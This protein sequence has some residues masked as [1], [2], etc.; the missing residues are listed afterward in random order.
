MARVFALSPRSLVAVGCWAVTAGLAAA[1]LIL[2][3]LQPDWEIL[4]LGLAAPVLGVA[5][6]LIFATVGAVIASRQPWNLVGWIFC[7]GALLIGFGMFAAP[8][9]AYAL[10]VRPGSL[11]AGELVAWVWKWSYVPTFG[12]IGILLPLLFPNGRLA[13]AR[14]RPVLWL[15]VPVL[16]IMTAGSAFG[17]EPIYLNWKLHYVLPNAFALGAP[18]ALVGSG[19]LWH[20]LERV[21]PVSV[22]PL[23]IVAAISLVARAS[24]ADAVERQQIKW[25]AF[26]A[27]LPGTGF[28]ISLVLGFWD[29]GSLLLLVG[30]FGL[31]IAA[32]VAILR[33]RLYEIDLLI[34]RTIV[35]GVLSLVLAATYFV[36]LLALQALLRP[37]TGASEL[38]VALSTL[39]VVGLVQPLRR[40]IQEDVDRRFYRSRYD[41]ARTLDAFS[42]RLRDLVELGAVEG[43]LLAAVHRTM[44]PASAGL[45]L[46]SVPGEIRA[47]TPLQRI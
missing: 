43:E 10:F 26:A 27:M 44:R 20:Q 5:L 34:N 24:R 25:V 22:V 6:A 13:S 46:R 31:P 15:A 8:Y 4:L 14:W 2:L 39:T 42:A 47:N 23:M 12:L 40:R 18:S 1:T 30:A 7:A 17:L 38:P 41:A 21:A 28:F 19:T 37:V 35:Y 3:A 33:Y 32:G 36:G 16:V 45:W 11:P 9:A 29:L